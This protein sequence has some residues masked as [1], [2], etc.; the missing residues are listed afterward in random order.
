MVR[1]LREHEK[2][3]KG[4]TE[5][6]IHALKISIGAEPPDP[7]G[8]GPYTRDWVA[9]ALKKIGKTNV[10]GKMVLFILRENDLLRILPYVP[11][12]VEDENRGLKLSGDKDGD[13]IL[14]RHEESEFM[15]RLMQDAAGKTRGLP[16]P[17][18]QPDDE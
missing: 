4:L 1:A 6:E 15:R 7:P 10:L 5:D 3:L 14:L 16:G 18:E 11:K 2:I 13:P 9:K 17:H 8:G 12:F